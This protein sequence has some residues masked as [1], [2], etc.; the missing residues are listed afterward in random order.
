VILDCDLLVG[1]DVTTGA[2]L[3]LDDLVHTLR[4]V[5]IDGGLV[6]SLRAL[7]FDPVSGNDEARASTA[8]PSWWGVA[9]IDL[10]DP[11]GAE[12]EID[13]AAS[14]GVRA[15]RLAPERQGVP[16]TAP[17][18]RACARR[19]TALGLALLVEG[20][21]RTLGPALTG[22]DATAV[23]L[24][25]HFYHLGDFV[26]LARDEAGFHA[27]TR[28][29]GNLDAWETVVTELGPDRLL[30]G[31]RAGWCEA[32]AVLMRLAHSGLDQPARDLVAAGNLRRLVSS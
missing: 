20:D 23:F 17:G 12:R 22:L 5:G 1:R 21:V 18:L 32:E 24:D 19:A 28:L 27:S 10:R 7:T 14:Q 2:R 13:R 15:V 9:G 4:R 29:L 6:A 26:V 30:F 25:L 16:T 31:S 3:P 8:D 11:L